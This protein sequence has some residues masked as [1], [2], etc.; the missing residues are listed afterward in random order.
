M[1]DSSSGPITRRASA[2]IAARQSQ[3]PETP[4]PPP[5]TPSRRARGSVTPS[6][7]P[8]TPKT[9]ASRGRKKASVEPEELSASRRTP[10]GSRSSSSVEVL[11]DQVT[12]RT[13]RSRTT[14]KSSVTGP[15]PSPTRRSTRLSKLNVIPEDTEARRLSFGTEGAKDDDDDSS[16]DIQFIEEVPAS[17]KST[18]KAVDNTAETEE[19]VNEPL[20]DQETPKSTRSR[21][22]SEKSPKKSD[23][24]EQKTSKTPVVDVK[25]P[26]SARSTKATPTNGEPVEVETL[27][28]E[29]KSPKTRSAKSTPKADIASSESETSVADA[30][31][32]A[33]RSAK[34]TPK[35]AEPATKTATPATEAPTPLATR[36][37]KSTPKSNVP[38]PKSST[39]KQSPAIARLKKTFW[40][41]SPLNDSK[42]DLEPMEVDSPSAFKSPK[43]S[44]SDSANKLDFDKDSESPKNGASD[45]SEES[46]EDEAEPEEPAPKTPSPVKASPKK[47]ATPI[48]VVTLESDSDA[49]AVT[50]K[51]ASPQKVATPKGT[52]QKPASAKSTPKVAEPSPK[53]AAKEPS[54]SPDLTSDDSE[55]E[56]VT[57]PSKSSASKSPKK[58][59]PVDSEDDDDDV[60]IANSGKSPK[61]PA[62]PVD[63]AAES[64]ETEDEDEI[65]ADSDGEDD[66]VKE[67][68]KEADSDDEDEDENADD[69]TKQSPAKSDLQRLVFLDQAS[70]EEEPE[71]EEEP[72]P[73]PAKRPARKR[74]SAATKA[75]Q[76]FSFIEMP[77]VE[78]FFKNRGTWS[79][80]LLANLQQSYKDLNSL[81]VFNYALPAELLVKDDDLEF[82]WQQIAEQNRAFF[83]SAKRVGRLLDQEIKLPGDEDEENSADE[84]DDEDDDDLS[85]ED[86]D[87]DVDMDD[88]T[89]PKKK[90][91][92]LFNLKE[93]DLANLDAKLKALDD[94]DNS[95]NSGD[96]GVAAAK[97]AEKP[98]K[99]SKKSVVDDE[100]FNLEEM[101]TFVDEQER[102][103]EPDVTDDDD[104][105]DFETDFRYD[106]FFVGDKTE[107]KK[108]ASKKVRFAAEDDV[109]ESMEVD[110][111]PILL[112]G[113]EEKPKAPTTHQRSRER[114]M[115]Q[116]DKLQEENLNPRTWELSGEV[117]A[118]DRETN[119]LLEKYIEADFRQKQ[120]PINGQEK[121]D[122]IFSLVLRRLKDKLF[123]DVERKYRDDDAL[124][125]YRNMTIDMN[126][127][128]SLTAVYE[129][130]YRQQVNGE[131]G[132]GEDVDPEVKEIHVDMLKLFD[133]LDALCHLQFAPSKV[134]EE[135]KVVRNASA[136]RSE[137]VGPLAAAS[138]N[139]AL[140]A[141][142]EVA[143]HINAA[144][145]AKEERTKTDKL[146]ERR[147]KKHKQHDMAAAG[148]MPKVGKAKADDAAIA[149]SLAAPKQSK[150]GADFFKELQNTAI[151]EIKKKQETPA[152]AGTKKTKTKTDR[153]ETAAKYKA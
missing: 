11:E 36:S 105:D 95:D 99:S 110:D 4:K 68:G 27:E 143:R 116:I 97:P 137:E 59:V 148:K 136:M 3:E 75:V 141:P 2:R 73:T 89:A 144:P 90:G 88:E 25:T 108:N 14:S 60:P 6:K 106:D 69:D 83:K 15:S 112:G 50:L 61:L 51:A 121:S 140:L 96:E 94:D 98:K 45:E 119:S 113:E 38:T 126:E 82:S 134:S 127:R 65:M 1:D 47:P 77:S 151:R 153:S 56:E 109:A 28:T 52:P 117:H 39:L 142:E 42:V 101:E 103:E 55:A 9:P 62:I 48:E 74:R 80:E 138:A 152:A 33:P 66:A 102:L 20:K 71:A 30:K 64:D 19:N 29:I 58:V 32:P 114:V 149:K 49:D 135:V 22:N 8:A 92:D 79:A 63:A 12:P 31:T 41:Q 100:F 34:S 57:T 26:Q 104:N 40:Q 85:A 76:P 93:S 122:K 111:A 43:S 91:V 150:A 132:D 107:K 17:K 123:D 46:S 133:N 130:K 24:V 139:E 129:D 23:T 125:P 37:T 18:P 115:A 131:T 54:A 35:S 5:S 146:R 70:S 10:G 87:D 44:N 120:P 124:T 16:S 53:K 145:M 21:A 86:E 13:T 78:E 118:V 7:A 147:K 81:N 72:E 84:L 128:K 67:N